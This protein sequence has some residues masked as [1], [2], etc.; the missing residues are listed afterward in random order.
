MEGRVQRGYRAVFAPGEARED[1]SIYRA[2]SEVLGQTLPYDS[3]E[4]LRA[5]IAAEWPHLGQEGLTASAWGDFGGDARLEGGAVRLPV[6]NFYTT[7]AVARAS[8]TMAE[9]VAQILNGH[10]PALQAAQ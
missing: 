8:A 6:T 5:R 4:A 9:C 1:W 2:L 3:L 10:E 7:N